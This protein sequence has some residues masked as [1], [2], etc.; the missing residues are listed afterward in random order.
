MATGEV[1]PEVPDDVTV[2]KKR[3]RSQT[4]SVLMLL[5]VSKKLSVNKK[6]LVQ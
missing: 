4:S 1:M 5:T 6:F 2:D 3:H